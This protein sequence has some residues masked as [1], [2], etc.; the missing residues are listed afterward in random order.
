[1][2]SRKDQLIKRT[3]EYGIGRYDFLRQLINEFAT[4]TSYENKKQTL[5]NLANFSYDP[6]NYDFIKQLHLIDLFLSE[7]SNDQEELIHFA[8]AG[9]CNLSCDPEIQE[10]IISLNGIKLISGYLQHDNIEISLNA[11]TTLYYLFE[12]RT[13]L[14]TKEIES[15]ISKQ[16]LSSNQRLKNLA[17]VFLLAYCP[18][19]K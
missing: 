10:Y 1:M 12:T 8:L 13:H 14:I 4:T 5:A 18:K 6:I 7:L 15:V 2:F 16:E 17:S 19:A 9:L 3:G 11:L